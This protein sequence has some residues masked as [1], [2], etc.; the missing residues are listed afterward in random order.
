MHAAPLRVPAEM[1]IHR[2]D[3]D[4]AR[5]VP[6]R[7][8]ARTTIGLRLDP[9]ARDRNWLTV[10]PPGGWDTGWEDFIAN[11]CHAMFGFE[12]TWSYGLHDGRA[13]LT[14]GSEVLLGHPHV[15]WLRIG[16]HRV[17]PLAEGQACCAGISHWPPR[18]SRTGEHGPVESLLATVCIRT[19]LNVLNHDRMLS[20]VDA[21]NDPPLSGEPRAVQ[22]AELSPEGL[23]DTARH[24]QQ[25]AGD[26]FHRSGGHVLRQPLRDRSSSGT[27]HPE[28]VA[29]SAHFLRSASSARAAWVP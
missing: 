10:L 4:R 17:L 6:N 20:L 23:A 2:K 24:I 11:L 19:M 12:I 28:L 5:G 26:D 16:D 7:G 27:G 3:L 9:A 21:V 14:Y 18:R 25:R 29:V 15:I 8:G 1:D 22:P 13:I